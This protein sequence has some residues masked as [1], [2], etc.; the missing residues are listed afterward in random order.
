L[1]LEFLVFQGFQVLRWVLEFLDY[2]QVLWILADQLIQ[3]RL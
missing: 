3:S 2:Q 1:N